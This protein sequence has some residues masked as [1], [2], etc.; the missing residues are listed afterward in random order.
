MRSPTANR[1][2]PVLLIVLFAAPALAYDCTIASTPLNFGALAG[3]AGATRQ[4]TATITVVCRSG[5]AAANVSYQILLDGPAGEGQRQMSAGG[6]SADYQ[7]YTSGNYQQ[8]WGNSGGGVITDGYSLDANAT[9][10][11]TYTVYA[12]MKADR[13]DPP[14]SYIANTAVQLLY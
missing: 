8:V 2:L 4:T 14:G 6:H 10:T 11:R 5:A 9:V 13:D 12:K 3:V 1:T 7:L